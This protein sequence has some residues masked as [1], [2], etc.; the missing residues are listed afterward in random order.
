MNLDWKTNKRWP[1]LWS[2]VLWIL[3]V[4]AC[5][6]LQKWKT[7]WRKGDDSSKVEVNKGVAEK[8]KVNSYFQAQRAAIADVLEGQGKLTSNEKVDIRTDKRMRL[9]PA[10]FK[11]MDKVRRGDV[12]FIVDTK[13]LEQKRTELKD[14]VAQLKLDLNAAKAQ[15]SFAT[16]QLERKKV[17]KTKGIAPQKELDEAEKLYFAGDTD[18]KTKEL[19]LRKSERE[20]ETAT[21][22]VSQ[23]NVVAP[24]D[25]FV[26]SIVAGGDEVNAGS[27]IASISNPSELILTASVDEVQ[28]TKLSIG[29]VVDVSIEAQPTSQF[30]GKVKKK[31]LQ[32]GQ[33]MQGSGGAPMNSYQLGIQISSEDVKKFQL[34]DGFAAKFRVVFQSKNKALVVPRAALKQSG[35]ETFVL[36]SSA[37]GQTPS[38]RAVKVGILSD[39]ESE[40]IEGVK[41]GEYVVAQSQEDGAGL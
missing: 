9:G 8:G 4:S 10:K 16:K 23:A 6:K 19:E 32:A 7:Q 29:Q 34:K 31:E 22:S 37:K 17:L 15:F 24:F 12:L 40:I 36:V 14:R 18:V 5:Q 30:T 21:Q 28:V 3:T 39:L 33:S 2:I 1:L 35:A 41:D 13:E 25:G 11:V 26:S 38:A 20:F 27:T